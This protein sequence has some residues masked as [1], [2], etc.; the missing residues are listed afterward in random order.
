MRHRRALLAALLVLAFGCAGKIAPVDAGGPSVTP[1]AGVCAFFACEADCDVANPCVPTPTDVAC[2]SNA[3][4]TSFE[5]P[6]CGCS[7]LVYGVNNGAIAAIF[8]ECPPL[9]C[10]IAPNACVDAADGLYTQDCELS[11]RGQNVL[12]ACLDHRCRTFEPAAGSE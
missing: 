11:P 9:P 7:S 3:D 2:N 8:R 1:D 6:S 12:A 5:K 10:V 4:C